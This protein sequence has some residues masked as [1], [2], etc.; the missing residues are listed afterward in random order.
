MLGGSCSPCCEACSAETAAALT[1]QLK[2]MTA[3]IQVTQSGYVPQ[4]AIS[5]ATV[6]AVVANSWGDSQDGT[7]ASLADAQSALASNFSSAVSIATCSLWE[8]ESQISTSPYLLALDASKSEPTFVYDDAHI[9]ISAACGY[10]T[11]SAYGVQGLSQCSF[12]WTVR[13]FKKRRAAFS[14]PFSNVFAAQ[15]KETTY[16]PDSQQY[17]ASQISF[18]SAAKWLD[19]DYVTVSSLSGSQFQPFQ[20][21]KGP[22]RFSTGGFIKTSVPQYSSYGNPV[23][24]FVYSN[25]SLDPNPPVTQVSFA[26]DASSVA[27]TLGSQTRQNNAFAMLTRDPLNALHGRYASQPNFKVTR[28]GPI[29]AKFDYD[30]P[31]SDKTFALA[32]SSYTVAAVLTLSAS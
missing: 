10:A 25:S 6:P 29:D 28:S 4:Q 17:F 20:P 7:T 32:A 15:T 1:N 21:N 13:I 26:E 12:N 30:V 19:W 27:M 14:I 5:S 9:N 16:G 18:A 24:T 3:T 11:A 23:T 8:A 31:V 22:Y 2:A